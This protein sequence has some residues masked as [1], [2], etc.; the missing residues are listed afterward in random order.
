MDRETRRLVEEFRRNDAGPIENNLIDE[1]I[2][3]DLDRQEFLRRASVFG[4]GAGTIGLLLRYIGEADLAFAA[5]VAGKAG[6]TLRVGMLGFG[7]SLEP[8]QLREAGSLGLAGIPGEYLTFSNPALQVKPWLATSWKPNANGTVWTFQLRRGVKFHNGK[9]MTADDVVASFK[10]YLSQPTSQILASIPP[11]LLGPEGVVKTGPYTVQFRLKSPNAAIPWLVS[12][13]TYQA[14]IQPAAIA[15]KP[16]T[17]VASGMIGT[18]AFRLKSYTPNRRAEL[19]R[20]PRYWGGRPPLDG[21]VLTFY[22]GSAPMVLALRAG[23]LD[24]CQQLSPQEGRAFRNNSRY[25]VYTSP[26]SHHTMFGLRVDRDPFRDPRVRRA[27]ALAIGRPDI[28]ARVLLGQ[29]TLGNDSPF[30]SRFPS[31]D[32]SIHQ[33]KKNVALAKALLQAAGQPN[34]KFTITTWNG[35]ELPDYA[36]AVQAMGREAGIDIDLEVMSNDDYYG[37]GADYYATTPWINRQATMTEYGAAGVPNRYLTAAY[38]SD[39]IW[40]AAHY[41]NA[42]FD[43]AAKSFLAAPDLK[44]QRAATKK[45]AGILLRDTPVITAYFNTYVTA[46]SS[47][48]KNYQVESLSQVRIAHTSLA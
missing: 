47:K 14:I 42:A 12:Q 31:T 48:V 9:T 1:L 40:N 28:I 43:S 27:V 25:K 16:G 29:G 4:L 10:Q 37:G 20:F 17:W 33:R 5:P 30:W 3:G 41:K 39:G 15:A 8:Y 22:E 44:G 26:S 2:E 24:L 34:P 13:T 45:L 32:P 19:V 6:G 35:I 23:Q 36:T 46:A 18:G 38:Q 21:A 11:N 7:S